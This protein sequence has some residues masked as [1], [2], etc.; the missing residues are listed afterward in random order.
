M[1]INDSIIPGGLSGDLVTYIQ[2]NPIGYVPFR[3]LRNLSG[4]GILSEK[5]QIPFV[6]SVLFPFALVSYL[7]ASRAKYLLLSAVTRRSKPH[8]NASPDHIFVLGSTKKYRTHSLSTISSKLADEQTD[9]VLLCSP[10]AEDRRTEWENDGH[11]V[12]THRELHSNVPVTKIPAYLFKSIQIAKNVSKRSPYETTFHQ[13]Y[14]AYNYTVIEYVKR[15]SVENLMEDDPCVHTYSPMPYLVENTKSEKIFVYQHGIQWMKN[16][17][18]GMSTP[19]YTPLTYLVWGELWIDNFEGVAHPDSRII[20]TGSPWHDHLAESNIER[21]PKFDVLFISQSHNYV[22]REEQSS[23]KKYEELVRKLAEYCRTNDLEL[24]IKLHPNEAESWYRERGLES[25]IS[26]FE[27]IDD[28]L[29]QTRI[30]VTDLSSAFIESSV[31]RTPIVVTDIRNIG[32]SSLAPVE[33]VLFPDDVDDLPTALE[34]ALSSN[35]PETERQ[36]VKT[37]GAT[38]RILSVVNS[39]C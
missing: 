16:D 24:R 15:K 5:D 8:E 36:I 6:T 33:N 14:V 10:S 18:I 30:A 23:E 38:E 3:V 20:P 1:T 28:A 37:D 11:T 29:K 4:G 22:G 35:L 19:F 31:Y 12:I 9:T 17:T 34:D 21:E 13:K 26:E 32:L 7:I 25:Y 39:E 27:D 2:Q